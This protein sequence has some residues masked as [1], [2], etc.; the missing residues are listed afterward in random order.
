MLSV[1]TVTV[2]IHCLKHLWFKFPVAPR[3]APGSRG[4]RGNVEDLASIVFM[5]FKQY[6][7]FNMRM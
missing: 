4:L 6:K 5:L 7:L 1:Q 3:C 2:K